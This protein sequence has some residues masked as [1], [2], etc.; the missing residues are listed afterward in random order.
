MYRAVSW[1]MSIGHPEI[2][3]FEA[4]L[5]QLGPDQ[6]W[7]GVHFSASGN[8]AEA[9]GQPLF[10]FSRRTDDMLFAFSDGDWCC[11]KELFSPA[12][13]GPGLR[14]LLDHLSLNSPELS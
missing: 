8:T 11:L 12:L 9:E 7:D 4:M 14:P 5:R 1:S 6:T 3:E 13:G 2:R 10:Y